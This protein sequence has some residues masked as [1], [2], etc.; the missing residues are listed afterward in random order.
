[1]P[2]DSLVGIDEQRKDRPMKTSARVTLVAL[3]FFY[4]PLAQADTFGSGANQFDIEFVPIG[5]PR[6]LPDT[7]G[8]PNPAGSVA[9]T[10]N[11]GKFDVSRDMINKANTLGNLGITLGNMT[12]YGGN[13]VNR[14]ATGV[15]WNEAARFTNWLN[16][17]TGRRPAYKFALQPGEVGYD[18]NANIEL[19]TISDAGFDPN[20]LYRNNLARYFLP[21]VH[22]WYK[23]A[24]YDPITSVYYDYPTGSNSAPTAVASGT[25]AGTAVYGQ[26][27]ATGPADIT[28]AGGLSPYGT[29]G[30]GGNVVHWE[31]TDLDRV[32][33]SS[34]S[35]RGIRGGDWN[36][37]SDG[38]FFLSSSFRH[39]LIPTYGSSRVGFRVASI[40]E[41]STMLMGALGAAGLL[42]WR[43]R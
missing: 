41:P 10:Y 33:D 12:P 25:A 17:I 18:A 23:A 36:L 3:T 21:S 39:G 24:F 22:E 37:D 29:M 38:F 20:N 32:N 4:A 19:W 30:Q 6:N 42:V 26:L 35:N 14:P 34:S 28:L 15:S 27:S 9:Y 1:M 13:G 40:P 16:T 7:T 5:D 43:R 31:E 2:H 8:D 11:M